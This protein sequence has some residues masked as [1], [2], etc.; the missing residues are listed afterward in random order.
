MKDTIVQ[1][2]EERMNAIM[3]FIRKI[4]FLSTCY[5]FFALL[6]SGC[7]GIKQIVQKDSPRDKYE[8]SLELSGLTNAAL[9]REWKIAGEKV[10]QDTFEI[11]IPFKEAG[12]FFSDRANALS[13]CFEAKKG[14]RLLI[15]LERDEIHKML[16]FMELFTVQGKGNSRSLKRVA[17]AD[18]TQLTIEEEASKNQKYLLR[19]QPE[20]MNGGRYIL[21]IAINPSLAFPVKGKDARAIG[22]RFGDGRDN[23]KR[24]HEGVDIFAPKRNPVVAV[25]DGIITRTSNGGLGGKVIWMSGLHDHENFYYAHL[26]SQIV[27]PGETVKQGEILGLVGNTGNAR[28]SSPHLHFGIYLPGAGAIDPFPFINDIGKRPADIQADQDNIG[29]WARIKSNK[30]F[31]KSAPEIKSAVIRALDVNTPVE[32]YA[33]SSNFYK[34]KLPGSLDGFVES[35]YVEKAIGYKYIAKLDKSRPIFDAPAGN[36]VLIEYLSENANLKIYGEY[37]GFFLVRNND[38]WGWIAK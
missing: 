27:H 33:A 34:V 18:S 37:N 6:V 35:K 4:C 28:H 9:G 12:Y 14:E 15:K 13:Y 36:G 17:F 22:S 7:G 5:L 11:K 24:K 31:L 3:T 8:K 38:Y 23:G 2:K 1:L 19:L 10:L 21:T 30:A 29:S 25:T 26:D 20:L 32:I 16:V